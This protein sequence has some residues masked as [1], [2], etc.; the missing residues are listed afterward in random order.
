MLH[1]EIDES[2]LF[3]RSMQFLGELMSC[4][5][6]C[7]FLLSLPRDPYDKAEEARVRCHYFEEEV[8][9]WK[10]LITVSVIY[11]FVIDSFN[12]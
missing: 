11:L 7:R 5:G 1:L 2:T 6:L 9:A 3:M 4:V 10:Y 8:K 12:Q